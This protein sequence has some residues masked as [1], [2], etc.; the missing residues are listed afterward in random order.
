MLYMF[1]AAYSLISRVTCSKCCVC[2]NNH[3]LHYKFIASFSYKHWWAFF[4]ALLCF[5]ILL[6][7]LCSVPFPPKL[8]LRLAGN[9]KHEV[10]ACQG[11]TRV[12]LCRTY[13]KQGLI[14]VLYKGKAVKSNFRLGKWKQWIIKT[15]AVSIHV[16]L[17][18]RTRSRINLRFLNCVPFC[19]FWHTLQFGRWFKFLLPAA[20][21]MMTTSQ[22]F[23]ISHFDKNFQTAHLTSQNRKKISLKSFEFKL[24][25][26]S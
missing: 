3:L 9:W 2:L 16:W 20:T 13:P 6:S 5:N 25:H 14:R 15:W 10:E 18:M 8:K 19:S 26:M 24:T 17:G 4:Q 21:V 22:C 12:Y 11:R 1:K 7:A 23:W